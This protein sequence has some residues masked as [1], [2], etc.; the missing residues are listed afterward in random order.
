MDV[1]DFPP[2]PPEMLA[3][4]VAFADEDEGEAFDF[5]ESGD[6][7]PEADRPPPAPPVPSA[8]SSKDQSQNNTVSSHP[9]GHL[10]SPDPPA[11]STTSDTAPSSAD[12]TVATSRSSTAGEATTE[13]EETSAAEGTD[14]KETDL[15]PPPPPPLDDDAE[16]DPGRTGSEGQEVSS[17]DLHPPQAVPRTSPQGKSQWSGLAALLLTVFSVKSIHLLEKRMLWLNGPLILQTLH[18]WK[19]QTR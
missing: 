11:P 16:T 4:N 13:G 9:E 5:D 8:P 3:D 14:D 2:P 17:N 15:P 7:I 19:I 10:P 12:T 1:E 6:D 18:G